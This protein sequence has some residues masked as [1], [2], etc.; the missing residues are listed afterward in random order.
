MQFFIFGLLFLQYIVY[1]RD[2]IVNLTKGELTEEAERF[3]LKD[4][5]IPQLKRTRRKG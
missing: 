4:I 1:I 2:K 3:E 5:D